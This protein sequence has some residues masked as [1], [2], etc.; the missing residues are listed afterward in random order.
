MSLIEKKSWRLFDMCIDIFV[1][2]LILLFPSVAYSCDYQLTNTTGTVI[3]PSYENNIECL[4]VFNLSG[5]VNWS[6]FIISIRNSAMMNCLSAKQYLMSRDI[7]RNCFVS[8]V[9]NCLIHVWS[10]SVVIFNF[11]RS[12]CNFSVIIQRL[13]QVLLLIMYF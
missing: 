9:R 10:R 12:G 1:L 13:A 7:I 4:W 6:L 2:Y 11:V 3:F 5:S 8:P